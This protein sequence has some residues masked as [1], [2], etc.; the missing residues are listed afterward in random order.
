MLLVITP[1]SDEHPV[2]PL[3][4]LL[5]R[6]DGVGEGRR[7]AIV[8]DRR[9]LAPLLVD[10]RMAA[11]RGNSAG[12]TL[13]QGGTPSYGPVHSASRILSGTVALR[14]RRCGCWAGLRAGDSAKR[15]EGN[16]RRSGKQGAF[17]VVPLGK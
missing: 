6:L 11:P 14:L 4:G 1:K 10:A 8:G 13:S 17:H 3:A 12:L 5:K 16:E 9:D 15:N 7:G 2:E